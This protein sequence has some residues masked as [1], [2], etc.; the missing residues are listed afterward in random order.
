MKVSSQNEFALFG[1]HTA[2]YH[3]DRERERERENRRKN[4]FRVDKKR[5][6]A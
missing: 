3:R 5:T 1:C 4:M 2:V 6:Y